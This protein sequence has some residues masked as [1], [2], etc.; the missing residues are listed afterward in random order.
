MLSKNRIKYIN[1]LKIK[2]YRQLHEAFVVEGAKSV[3]EL[4]DSDFEI[5]FVLVTQEFQQKYS[6]ILTRHNVSFE[7]V[8]PKELEGLGSFQTNDSCLAVAK[9]KEN[10]F[11]SPAAG[12]YM[13]MLDDVRDPG[14]LGTIIR[15]ADW[16]GIT[17]IVCSRDTT[18]VY[19]PKVIAAAKG[20]FTRVSLYYTDLIQYFEQ[21][22]DVKRQVIGAFLGGNSLYEFEYP[23]NGGIIMMG[24][25]SNGISEQ[26][27]QFVTDKIM[28]PRFGAAESLNVG[29]ATAVML[30][31]MRRQVPL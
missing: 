22:K 10:A 6:S 1:S 5:E 8:T 7:T 23:T 17:R 25:E 4:F 30:D 15:V 11:L 20:S 29:I 24:N 31:N 26:V 14:N 3:L 12:E 18:D 27:G 28:I 19:N 21:I 13:L 9:T 2:K 16:Y